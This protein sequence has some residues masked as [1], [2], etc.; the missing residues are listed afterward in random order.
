MDIARLQRLIEQAVT[1]R[2]AIEHVDS[3]RTI[4]VDATATVSDTPTGR[5]SELV[6]PDAIVP[7]AI[8]APCFGIVHLSP[9]PD[10]VPF[11][12]AGDAIAAGQK[13]CLVEA[14]KVFTAVVSDR[15]GRLAEIM[16][17]SGDEVARGQALFRLETEGG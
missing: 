3:G 14:M 4:R 6:L 15:A 5:A 11:V 12:K 8:V 1:T 2:A 7:G 9:S 13:V 10:A 16:V 17:A